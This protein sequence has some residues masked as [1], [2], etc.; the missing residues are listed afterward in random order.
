M[1]NKDI[2]AVRD[3]IIGIINNASLPIE[4]NRLILSE[5]YTKVCETSENAIAQEV[6]NEQGTQPD[7]LAE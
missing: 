6:R 5:I 2:R 7:K 4:V 3:A 1:N